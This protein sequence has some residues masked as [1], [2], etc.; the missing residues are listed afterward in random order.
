MFVLSSCIDRFDYDFFSGWSRTKQCY[1][2]QQTVFWIKQK[3]YIYIIADQHH[4]SYGNQTVLPD[5]HLLLSH[6]Q[7]YVCVCMRIDKIISLTQHSNIIRST[8]EQSSAYES[9]QSCIQYSGVNIRIKLC[10]CEIKLCDGYDWGT[11]KLIENMFLTNNCG[12]I[13]FGFFLT[14]AIFYY[15]QL[16][17][18]VWNEEKTVI[19][20]SFDGASSEFDQNN[21]NNNDT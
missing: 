18:N 10:L 1:V 13:D 8:T 17:N 14:I 11:I 5:V 3:V 20:V 21:Y 15:F 12:R 7:L 19:F 2:H 4:T 9:L 6:S 16:K